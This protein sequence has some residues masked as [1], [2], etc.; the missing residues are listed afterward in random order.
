MTAKLLK[1]VYSAEDATDSFLM[2]KEIHRVENSREQDQRKKMKASYPIR[3]AEKIEKFND[4]IRLLKRRQRQNLDIET[5]VVGLQHQINDL[6]VRLIQVLDV[7]E[8]RVDQVIAMVGAGGSGKTTLARSVYNRIDVKR[9]FTIRAWEELNNSELITLKE[10]IL[11]IC[12]GLPSTIVLLGGVLSTKK[13]SCDEW[14]RVDTNFMCQA[15]SGL[16]GCW[17]LSTTS[18][19]SHLLSVVNSSEVKSCFLYMGIFTKRFHI[20]M[21]RLIHLLWCSEGFVTTPV[22]IKIDPEDVAEMCL[23]ELVTR[24]MVDVVRWGADGVPKT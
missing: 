23:E 18:T 4:E 16:S 1:A 11:K 15:S 6:V 2:S 5:H 13:K 8:S 12:G 17:K 24:H 9:H 14:S 20:P 7:Q 19:D 3:L 10:Q 22:P 21:R